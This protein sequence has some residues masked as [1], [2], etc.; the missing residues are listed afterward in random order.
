[1]IPVV[2]RTTE[3]VVKLVPTSLRE[4]A[5]ALGIPQWKVILRI[6]LSTAKAG[7]VTAIVLAV[8]RILGETAP[9]LFTAFGNQFWQTNPFQPMAAM[10]LQI[11]NYAISPYDDWHA[12]AWAGA[13][14]LVAMSLI[15]NITAR[16]FTMRG[17]KRTT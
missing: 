8:A 14:V 12:M 3:E 2:V 10:T 17:L 4:G 1:M 6:V 16:F 15:F 5:L 7:I 13:L 11:F 9:L